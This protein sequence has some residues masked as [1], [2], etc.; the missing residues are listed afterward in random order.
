MLEKNSSIKPKY[1]EKEK[2]HQSEAQKTVINERMRSPKNYNSIKS[3]RSPKK[4]VEKDKISLPNQVSAM[5]STVSNFEE[6]EEKKAE[7]LSPL[8]LKKYTTYN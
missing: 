3:V 4:Y 2:S 6:K 8:P 7:E 1:V 5:K